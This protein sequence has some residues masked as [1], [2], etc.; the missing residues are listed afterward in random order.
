MKQVELITIPFNSVVAT[1]LLINLLRPSST[2]RKGSGK[3]GHPYLNPLST[4]KKCV[5]ELLIGREKEA[6]LMLFMT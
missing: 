5:F 1:T 6:M 3:S 2:K 4:L